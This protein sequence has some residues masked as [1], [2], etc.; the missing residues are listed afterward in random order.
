MSLLTKATVT[1]LYT[2]ILKKKKKNLYASMI[3][4]SVSETPYIFIYLINVTNVL[5]EFLLT[6][7]VKH[8]KH[9]MTFCD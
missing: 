7:E 5:T 2:H 6:P 1:L 3:S 4:C 8:P 9:P